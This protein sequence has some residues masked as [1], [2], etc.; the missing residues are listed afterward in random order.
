MMVFPEIITMKL[1]N[2]H[3]DFQISLQCFQKIIVMISGKKGVFAMSRL[4]NCRFP[5]FLIRFSQKYA[6]A[7][8]AFFKN[9]VT[10]EPFMI[11]KR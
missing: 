1:E 6:L 3:N 10:K 2:H 5:L 9:I 7:E 4:Q 8:T 11:T